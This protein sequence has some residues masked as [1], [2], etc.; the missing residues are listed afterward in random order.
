M[1]AG[2]S[3]FLTHFHA[4]TLKKKQMYVRASIKLLTNC[5][6]RHKSLL[7]ANSKLVT[8]TLIKM[9]DDL[10]AVIMNSKY[11]ILYNLDF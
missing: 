7:S 3:P 6:T 5:T 2:Y 8:N 9:L 1:A 11:T 10:E 4:T